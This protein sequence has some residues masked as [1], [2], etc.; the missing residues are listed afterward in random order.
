MRYE[1]HRLIR[2]RELA[3]EQHDPRDRRRARGRSR[4][5]AVVRRSAGNAG[6][7]IG[8]STKNG[9]PMTVDD[10]ERDG[11]GARRRGEEDERGGR[12]HLARRRDGAQHA[13]GRDEEVVRRD[14][15]ADER[16][17]QPARSPRRAPGARTGT[18]GERPEPVDLR[19]GASRDRARRR[20]VDDERR[21]QE[22]SR[23]RREATKARGQAAH[24][25][26]CGR[27]SATSHTRM[28]A[29]SSD[30]QRAGADC[31]SS[32]ASASRW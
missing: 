29:T 6:A 28:V 7:I 12:K 20:E 16:I 17:D 30:L 19:D 13:V 15:E 1:L 14:E 3:D 32:R 23:E 25:R 11:E 26:R 5:V 21:Q 31:A 18:S 27:V 22:K 4:K 24:L 10:G 9:E 2:L 8:T